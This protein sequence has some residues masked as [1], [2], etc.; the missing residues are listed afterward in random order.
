MIGT[1][2]TAIH[3]PEGANVF[4]GLVY[5]ILFAACLLLIYGIVFSIFVKPVKGVLLFR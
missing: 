1:V 4:L 2:I 5:F 3:Q